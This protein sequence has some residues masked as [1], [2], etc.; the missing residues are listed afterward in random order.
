MFKYLKLIYIHEDLKLKY[1]L[2][3]K[4]YYNSIEN[5]I[6]LCQIMKRKRSYCDILLE[7]NKET[8]QSNKETTQSN[9]VTSQSNKETLKR[10]LSFSDWLPLLKTI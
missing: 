7:F 1:I 6:L 4:I 9:K 2:Y 5:N 8:S 10:N 3:N